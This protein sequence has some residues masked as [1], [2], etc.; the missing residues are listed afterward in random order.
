M[1]TTLELHGE[2]FPERQLAPI[3]PCPEN[4]IR[5]GRMSRIKYGVPGITELALTL[6]RCFAND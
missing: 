5:H 6:P 3:Q 1:V 4:S 2:E